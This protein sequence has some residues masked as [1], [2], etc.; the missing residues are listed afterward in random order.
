[1]TDPAPIDAVRADEFVRARAIFESALER[2]QAERRQLVRDACGEDTGLLSA[3]EEMLRADAEP[4]P[5]LD[6]AHADTDRWRPGDVPS[7]PD[8]ATRERSSAHRTPRAIRA[9]PARLPEQTPRGLLV[10][11]PWAVA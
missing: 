2:P 10:M 7:N 4:H 1:M 5:L 8:Q 6:G 11:S 3:V 9:D